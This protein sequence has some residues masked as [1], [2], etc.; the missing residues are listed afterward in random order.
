MPLVPDTAW[1][2]DAMKNTLMKERKP[3]FAVQHALDQFH[4][5]DLSL[6]LTAQY[7]VRRYEPQSIPCPSDG[8]LIGNGN[9]LE[10]ESEGK[11]RRTIWIGLSFGPL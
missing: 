4:P 9:V 3:C 10:D 8:S 6:H 2:L 5:R 1:S 11:S 7:Y